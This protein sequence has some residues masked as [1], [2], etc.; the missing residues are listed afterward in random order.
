M[1]TYVVYNFMNIHLKFNKEGNKK[2]NEYF[3]Q[4]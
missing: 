3:S 1:S 2:T 4:N